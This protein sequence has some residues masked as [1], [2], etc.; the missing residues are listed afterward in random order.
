VGGKVGLGVGV[1]TVVSGGVNEGGGGVW[2]MLGST[3]ELGD[4]VSG[5]GNVGTSLATRVFSESGSGML[6]PGVTTSE[7]PTRVEDDV[8]QAGR[9]IPNNRRMNHFFILCSSTAN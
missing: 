3:V 6:N 5:M 1:S 7:T 4:S 9:K 2:V 8:P